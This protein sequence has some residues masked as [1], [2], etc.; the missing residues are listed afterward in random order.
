MTAVDFTAFVVR[1]YVGQDVV[2]R[3]Y[4][5]TYG[6]FIVGSGT[7]P[8]LMST[9]FDRFGTYATGALVF[10]AASVG[11]ALLTFAM[12]AYAAPGQPGPA[13]SRVA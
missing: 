12:P 1:R 4:G 11:V 10:A 6:L 3:L 7:G 9:S 8:V 5:V 2:G 13:V